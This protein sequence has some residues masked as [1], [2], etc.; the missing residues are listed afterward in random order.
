MTLPLPNLDDRQFQDL[1]NEAKRRIPRYTAEWT[2]HNVSDPGVTLIELFAWMVET[3][4][5]RVNQVPRLHFI[6]F[7]ELFGIKLRG[8]HAAETAMTFWFSAPQ[9]TEVTIPAGTEVSTTQTETIPPV[10]FATNRRAEVRIPRLVTVCTYENEHGIERYT[11]RN[12]LLSEEGVPHGV[13]IFSAQPKQ[14]DAF[15]FGF[16]NDLSHH[17]LRLGFEMELLAA[18]NLIEATPPWAWE[19]STGDPS[20]PWA[21]C[22][23]DDVNTIG[24]LNRSGV[25]QL[26]LPAM[27]ELQLGEY[28]HFW[29]RVRVTEAQLNR[30]T[31]GYRTS[32][33][34]KRVTQ[35]ASVGCTV[36]ASHAEVIR[37]EVLG[38]SNGLPGQVFF[39]QNPPLLA[40]RPD[41]RLR[42]AVP[43]KDD[44]FWIEVPDFADKIPDG[45]YYTLDSVTGELRFAPAIRQRDGSIQQFGAI[46]TRGATLIFDSY[47][48]GGGLKGNVKR[49]ELDTL[50][51]S[52][53][54]VSR[55]A[56]R[57]DANGG[58]DAQTVDDAILEMPRRLRSRERAV[59]ADDFEYLV[60]REFYSTIGRAKC[61]PPLHISE[62]ALGEPD[63]H[64][65]VRIIPR[66]PVSQVRWS[67]PDAA[68][69]ADLCARV[70]QFLD[71]RRLLTTQLRVAA[72]NYHWV[73][74]DVEVLAAPGAD[75]AL[76]RDLMLRSLYHFLH[77][78]TGGFDETGW[79]FGQ[80]LRKWE[81]Y[82]FLKAPRRLATSQQESTALQAVLDLN[83]ALFAARAS[84]EREGDPLEEIVVER[85]GV[86]ASGTHH[87]SFIGK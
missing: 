75:T 19:V 73:V 14:D 80:N 18:E 55:V 12:R 22:E 33:R 13:E 9:P 48:H 23:I 81:V 35:A 56:N 71:Q 84:G 62:G 74:V 60:E 38:I 31:G 27:G 85:D 29:L 8:P 20:R 49:G 77:P 1:V 57:A 11:H 5:Y 3:L 69:M 45:K 16:E 65:D 17:I 87:V 44:E 82:Q 79:P 66:L 76:I 52:I 78:L 54:Y 10:I 36:D 26:H 61:L 6:K 53:P 2:D 70:K 21:Q 37:G 24:G 72:P 32:P 40:R 63:Y 34:M 15:Y 39:L 64:V 4:I 68:A 47:R 28:K 25:I 58:F 51:S 50:K 30:E 7:M 67:E 86:I 41:E 83:I 42:V 43:G 46:P 59:T